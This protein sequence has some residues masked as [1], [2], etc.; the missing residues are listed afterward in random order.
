MGNVNIKKGKSKKYGTVI[1]IIT[2]NVYTVEHWTTQIQLLFKSNK[3]STKC[4][5]KRSKSS[6]PIMNLSNVYLAHTI[7]TLDYTQTKNVQYSLKN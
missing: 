6:Y 4:V 5:L 2:I 1:I 7:K 3:Y